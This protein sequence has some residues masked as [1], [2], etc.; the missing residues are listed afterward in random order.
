MSDRRLSA[1]TVGVAVFL[2]GWILKDSISAVAGHVVRHNT[3]A[4]PVSAATR[5]ASEVAAPT[6]A[7]LPTTPTATPQTVLPAATEL[8][9][10]DQLARSDIRRR[11]RASVGYTYLDEIVAESTDSALHRWDDRSTTPVRVYLGQD[12]VE[13]FRPAFLGSVRT[14]FERW[15]DAGVPVRFDLDAD[16]D[17]AE[18]AVHWKE[19][20]NIERT[21]QT[22]LAWDNEG[23]I[24][25]ALITIA[26]FDPGGRP[27]SPD[28]V[29]VVALHEIGHLIGLDHSTDSTDIMFAKTRAR[30]LSPR[31]I[32]TAM[33]LYQLAPGSVR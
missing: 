2:A 30:D 5:A 25:R 33:L 26:T 29:R 4:H 13:N 22:D 19:R 3:A 6:T 24:Q 9:Y 12:S 27:L 32:R 1:L 21:G 11:L 14:A 15:Q 23:R 7:P 18:V 20:F 28:D 8:S 17:H 16:S 31:D 10:I